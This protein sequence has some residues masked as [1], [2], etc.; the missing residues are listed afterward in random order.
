M[1]KKYDEQILATV[2]RRSYQPLKPKAL[3]RKLGISTP[4]YPD[5]RKALKELL[6]QGR[7]ELA[8]NHT[9][10][11]VAPHGTVTGTFRRTSTGTGYVRPHLIEGQSGTEIRIPESESLDAAAGDT[12]L[13]RL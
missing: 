10:R 2:G 9:I 1:P 8:K 12:V 6:Q 3:A 13:V 4:Q 7:L 11:P 5:Y